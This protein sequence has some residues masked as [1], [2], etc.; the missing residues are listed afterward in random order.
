MLSQ[1]Q[2][3]QTELIPT[4]MCHIYHQQVNRWTYSLAEFSLG[5]CRL[6]FLSRCRTL[7][8][9][10]IS[11]ISKV[12]IEKLGIASEKQIQLLPPFN[13]QF[14]HPEKSNESTNP[15]WQ[16]LSCSL[17]LYFTP[18]LLWGALSFIVL[19]SEMWRVEKHSIV[20]F[21]K[22]QEEAGR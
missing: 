19:N 1:S 10:D 14:L 11:P 16:D 3:V 8:F 5:Q 21:N 12:F 15:E 13:L 22:Y 20:K 17:I 6:P 9:S 7:E 4:I 2:W 18:Q